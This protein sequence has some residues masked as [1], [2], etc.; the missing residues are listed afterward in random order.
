MTEEQLEAIRKRAEKATEGPWFHTGYHVATKPGISGGYPPNSA[1]ICET[2]DG[3]YIENNNGINDASFIAH[4]R[5]DI[6]K[7]LAEIDRLRNGIAIAINETS[8]DDT[9][10]YLNRLLDGKE[11]LDLPYRFGGIAND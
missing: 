1:S 8:C 7:L 5:E 4:A 10:D 3:E 2:F 9:W 6:P 11:L